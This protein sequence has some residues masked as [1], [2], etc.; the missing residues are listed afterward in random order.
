M[1][2]K[3]INMLYLKYTTYTPHGIDFFSWQLLWEIEIMFNLFL[4]YVYLIITV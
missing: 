2:I 4:L 3:Q 1:E